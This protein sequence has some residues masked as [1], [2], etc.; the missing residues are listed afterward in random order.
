MSIASIFNVEVRCPFLDHRFAEFALS[1]PSDQ[2]FYAGYTKW[3]VRRSLRGRLP[4]SV[5][6]MFNKIV[7]SAIAERGLRERS[8]DTI[9]NLLSNMWLEEMGIVDANLVKQAYQDY[10]DNKTTSTSFFSP[11][12]VESWLRRWH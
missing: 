12:L 4:D 5:L 9:K 1:L 6:G 3:I 7:P 8:V 2:T 11:V 10:L